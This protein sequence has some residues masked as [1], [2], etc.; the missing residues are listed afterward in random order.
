MLLR[1]DGCMGEYPRHVQQ[2]SPPK[3]ENAV[4]FDNVFEV[5]EEKSISEHSV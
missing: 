2:V 5:G 1:Y 4:R 3:I